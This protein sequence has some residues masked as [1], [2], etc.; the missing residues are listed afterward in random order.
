MLLTLSVLIEAFYDY[1][2]SG[3]PHNGVHSRTNYHDFSIFLSINFFFLVAYLR[4]IFIMDGG[5][6]PL[7]PLMLYDFYFMLNDREIII[8]KDFTYIFTLHVDDTTHTYYPIHYEDRF[9][10]DFEKLP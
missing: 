8:K 10:Y 5:V 3:H 1:S 6:L 4:T 7:V 2:G 9:L